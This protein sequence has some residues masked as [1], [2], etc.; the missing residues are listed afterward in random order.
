MLMGGTP[1]LAAEPSTLCAARGGVPLSPRL[2]SH[3]LFISRFVKLVLS[4]AEESPFN[5]TA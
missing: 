3:Y 1:P 5:L 4:D 2:A